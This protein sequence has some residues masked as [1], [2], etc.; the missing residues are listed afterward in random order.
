MKRQLYIAGLI[1]LTMT[2]INF[3]AALVLET[4]NYSEGLDTFPDTL[5]F[6]GSFCVLYILTT[7]IP[8]KL[9][10][11]L[12]LPII[13]TII[14]TIFVASELFVKPTIDGEPSYILFLNNSG[15]CLFWPTF[16]HLGESS[17]VGCDFWTDNILINILLFGLYEIGIIKTATLAYNRIKNKS[18]TRQQRL[19][20]HAG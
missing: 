7:F 14:W 19:S 17:C 5:V 13:R 9:D 2:V 16:F 15:L 1:F 18:T 11:S 4:Q 6:I 3:I 10:N 12:K 20:K 8:I